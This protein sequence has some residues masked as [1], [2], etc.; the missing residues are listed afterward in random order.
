MLINSEELGR[1][2]MRIKHLMA[3]FLFF[4]G[5]KLVI[6]SAKIMGYKEIV[7]ELKKSQAIWLKK[8]AFKKVK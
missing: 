5:N 8:D 7:V 3:D 1:L 2:P 6:A 4:L